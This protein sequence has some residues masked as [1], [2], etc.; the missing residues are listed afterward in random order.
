MHLI[1]P[2]RLGKDAEVRFMPDGTAVANLALAFNY[3]PKDADGKRATQWVDAALFG[4]RAQKLQPYLLKGT[5]IDVH[6]SDPH[7]EL[8]TKSDGSP[9][10]KMVARLSHLE[11]VGSAPQQGGQQQPQQQR[12]QGQPSQREPRLNNQ[13]QQSRP[14][15]R[16]AANFSDMDDDI[17]F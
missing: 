3:G 14:A 2:A 15:P 17:P 11:F 16:P 4:D 1:G 10:Q 9:G 5:Q 12:P 7:I 13:H 8:F 6:L